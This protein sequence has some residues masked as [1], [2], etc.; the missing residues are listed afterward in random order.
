MYIYVHE[1]NRF[2]LCVVADSIHRMFTD[3]RYSHVH[4]G[5][6][7]RIKEEQAFMFFVDYLDDCERGIV[8]L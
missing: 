4:V 1:C 6:S 2:R 8:I 7:A 3:I 5:S